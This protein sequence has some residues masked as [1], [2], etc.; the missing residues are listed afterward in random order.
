MARALVRRFAVLGRYVPSVVGSIA[1]LLAA[2]CGS[3]S[4]SGSVPS[5]SSAAAT[6]STNSSI[7][8]VAGVDACSLVTA[9]EASAIVGTVREPVPLTRDSASTPAQCDYVGLDPNTN[10]ST[11]VEVTVR[12]TTPTEFAARCATS[13]TAFPGIGDA[14]CGAPKAFSLR[15]GTTEVDLVAATTLGAGQVTMNFS[16]LA[17]TIVSRL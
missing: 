5:T 3:S 8:G 7:P 16:V 9:S 1:I 6:S 10:S 11:K 14:A 12:A 2:G 4:P 15:K 17:K 13:G